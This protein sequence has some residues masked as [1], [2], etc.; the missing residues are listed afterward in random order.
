MVRV[1]P[2][3]ALDPARS[4]TFDLEAAQVGAIERT[5]RQ[6]RAARG[7]RPIA[8]VSDI[9][10]VY[11]YQSERA[12]LH[13]DRDVRWPEQAPHVVIV[14]VTRRRP[15]RRAMRMDNGAPFRVT[16]LDRR[17]HHLFAPLL[18]QVATAAL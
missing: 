8:S 1:P 14:G 6:R 18:Y 4:S 9:C 5:R 13:A 3:P 12:R 17:N 15:G 16:V 11:S 2:R 7:S 10:E